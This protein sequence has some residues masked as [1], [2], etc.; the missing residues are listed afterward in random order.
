MQLYDAYLYT[1]IGQLVINLAMF[2]NYFKNKTL[3]Q[4]HLNIITF[5]WEVNS[6]STITSGF[7]VE[8][9][10][11]MCHNILFNRP[12]IKKIKEQRCVF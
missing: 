9:Q 10:K 8:P 11:I 4:R 3:F 6:T 2:L 1:N 12:I 5:S 7:K